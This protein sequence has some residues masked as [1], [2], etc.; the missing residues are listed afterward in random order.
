MKTILQNILLT[1]IVWFLLASVY[2]SVEALDDFDLAKYGNEDKVEVLRTNF[3][4][5]LVLHTFPDELNEAFENTNGRPL[6]EGAGVRGFAIVS[7]TEDVC[8]VH[9]IPA[10]IW[11][12]RESMAI[13]GHEIYHCALADHERMLIDETDM[14]GL[15]DP[16]D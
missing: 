14:I 7:E 10:D 16:S 3:I 9:I 4:V 5:K 15:E 13:M 12:D 6:P 8:Y 1:A 2:S 11:D